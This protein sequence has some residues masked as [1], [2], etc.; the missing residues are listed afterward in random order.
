MIGDHYGHKEVLYACYV[1]ANI[2]YIVPYNQ[3]ITKVHWILTYK[4]LRVPL[5]FIR[6]NRL[7]HCE[8]CS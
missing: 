3:L 1:V 5:G 7:V 2:F 4:F 8:L 6:T